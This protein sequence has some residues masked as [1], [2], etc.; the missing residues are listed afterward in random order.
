MR[1]A[2]REIRQHGDIIAVLKECDT[3]RVSMNGDG[4]PYTIPVSYGISEKDGEIAIYFHCAPNG[5]KLDLIWNDDRVCF[6]CDRLI[7]Y[8]RTAHGITAGYR[9]VIGFGTCSFVTDKAEAAEGLRL[10]TAH[11]GFS[12]YP[13]EDCGAFERVRVCRIDV[14]SITGKENPIG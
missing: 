11:C 1:R 9:S 12:D 6:E 13:V 10:I 8:K 2:D 3:L 14:Q 4:Y 7:G 5:M